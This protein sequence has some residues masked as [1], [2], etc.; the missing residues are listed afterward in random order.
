ML[1]GN[2]GAGKS[3]VARGLRARYGH[4]LAWV[5]QDHLRRVVLGERD[6]PGA[7][8]IGLIDQTVRYALDAGFH[9]V[10][11]GILFTGHYREMLRALWADHL[12][13]TFGYYFDVPFDETVR[14]HAMRPQAADFTPAQMRCW[15]VPDDRL[16]I[17]G[18]KVIAASSLTDTVESI[19]REALVDAGRMR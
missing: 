12:G 7:A 16:R 2:S 6:R 5:E 3:S 8:N 14:R 10:C 4:G 9:V 17:D 11:E 1:R 19:Y 18:E 13:A 15:F